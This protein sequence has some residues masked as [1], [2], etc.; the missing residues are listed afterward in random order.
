LTRV[1]VVGAG[2]TGLAAAWRLIRSGI[3]VTIFDGAGRAGGRVG[4]AEF[5]DRLVDTGPDALGPDPA[6]D[7]LLGQIGMADQVEIPDPA[8]AFKLTS[9]GELEPFGVGG[10]AMFGLAGGI[11][12]LP[13]RLEEL[14][15][16][17]GAEFRLDTPVEA[18]EDRPDRVTLRTGEGEEEFDATVVA[19]GARAASRLL[20]GPVAEKLSAI[21]GLSVTLVHLAIPTARIGREMNGTGYLADPAEGR[22]VTGC[23]WSSV[24]WKRLAG[25]P[26]ILRASIREAGQATVI[27]LDDAAIVARVMDELAAV[28]EIEGDPVETALTRYADALVV[29]DDRHEEAVS[30]VRRELAGRPRIGLVGADLDGPGISR[31]IGGVRKTVDAIIEG[32]THD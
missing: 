9:A 17:G 25:E 2:V 12:S 31:S 19:T 4:S 15:R 8:Q 1:A 16:D 6:L 23:S 7:E 5:S 14:L 24:K 3:E 26:A 22:L 18:V 11:F 30:A 27:E 32:N 28:M 29:R 10:G 20:V 13:A 21:G